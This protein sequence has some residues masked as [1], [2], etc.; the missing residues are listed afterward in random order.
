MKFYDVEYQ[1]EDV[2]YLDADT[3]TKSNEDEFKRFKLLSDDLF[4]NN[5]KVLQE[6]CK[7][8]LGVDIMFATVVLEKNTSDHQL[9][10]LE[11]CTETGVNSM[12]RK[13]LMIVGRGE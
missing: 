10:W 1:V 3:Y 5:E 9:C 13:T 8:I 6:I 12:N 7:K 4:E 11:Y 2:E